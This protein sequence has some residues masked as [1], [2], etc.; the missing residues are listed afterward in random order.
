MGWSWGPIVWGW[1]PRTAALGTKVWV[2]GAVDLRL[3]VG[4]WDEGWG[5]MTGD[6]GFRLRDVDWGPVAGG[7]GTQGC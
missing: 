5:P 6:G 2:L 1:G 3:G 4:C 7:M